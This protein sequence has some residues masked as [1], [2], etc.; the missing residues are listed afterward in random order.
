MAAETAEHRSRVMAAVKGRDTGPE[1]AVARALRAAGVRYRRDVKRLPGTP[2]FVLVDARLALFVHG[3]F[4]HGHTCARGARVPRNNRPY[5]EAK[6][7]R[8]RRRDRRVARQLRARGYAV[9]TLWEC[10]LKD[11][12]PRRLL[13]EIE[14]RR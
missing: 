10:R 6:I 8:N 12:L 11:G 9:W 13:T 3:C 5:W 14:R 1:L 7:A 4:W 2:D